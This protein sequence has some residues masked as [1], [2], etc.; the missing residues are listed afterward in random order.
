MTA[1]TPNADSTKAS[2]EKDDGRGRAQHRLKLDPFDDDLQIQRWEEDGGSWR[3]ASQVD[4]D[5]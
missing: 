4:I 2:G 3:V 5:R 1:T